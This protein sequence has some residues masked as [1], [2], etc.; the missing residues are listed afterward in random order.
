MRRA[1]VGSV[2]RLAV[3][4][5]VVVVSL[6]LVGC[7]GRTGPSVEFVDDSRGLPTSG[8]WRQ[9]LAIVDLDGDGSAEIVA[10]PARRDAN[11]RPHVWRR[12]ED[13]GWV[14]EGMEFPERSYGY[15]DVVAEDFDRDGRPDL[16]FAMHG[17][18]VVV[19]LR[20]DDGWSVSMRGLPAPGAFPT[21]ALTAGDFDGDGWSD[22]VS[23]AEMTTRSGRGNPGARFHRNLEGEGWKTVEIPGAKQVFGDRVVASSW[24]GGSSTAFFL[25]SLV[26]GYSSLAWRHE[27]GAWRSFSEGLPDDVVFWDAATCDVDGA[28]PPELFLAID[29]P[30]AKKLAGPRTYAYREGSWIDRSEGLPVFPTRA[31]AAADL[32]DGRGCAVAATEVF[33]GDVQVYRRSNDGADGSWFRVAT[34]KRPDGVEGH[35][36]GIVLADT[37]RDGLRDVV[38]NYGADPSRGAIRV[39][40]RVQP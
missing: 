16:A 29:A 6:G 39:W 18:G 28:A 10:P 24:D 17:I 40:R 36:Y 33:S 2:S 13:G 25:G 8:E 7:P 5:V 19:L 3:S 27:D 30:R 38:V 1:N 26:A 31:I 34:L 11:P 4:S 9:R 21:R 12:D 14:E 15:G 22:L 23:L 37:N 20:R 35:P 32:G